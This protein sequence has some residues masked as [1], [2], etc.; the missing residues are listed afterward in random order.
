MVDRQSQGCH[1]AACRALVLEAGHSRTAVGRRTGADNLH[2]DLYLAVDSR[3]PAG[4]VVAVD[5]CQRSVDI[6][7]WRA[8]FADPDRVR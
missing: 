1:F 7:P 4:T 3:E 6:V 5:N 2:R 8:P